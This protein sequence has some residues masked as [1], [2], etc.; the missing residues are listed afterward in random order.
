MAGPYP[1]KLIHPIYR[2]RR[3]FFFFHCLAV[4]TPTSN[5]TFL[6]SEFPTLYTLS[7]K[8][9]FQLHHDPVAALFK[10]WVF[11]EKLVERLFAEHQLPPLVENTQHRRLEELKRQ[12]LLPRQVEDMLHLLKR[13]GNVAAH[14][15]SGSFQDAAVLLESVFHLGK[16]LVDSY[17]V[18]HD[19]GV[20]PT[21]LVP[22]H[23]YTQQE[24]A[25]LETEK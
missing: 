23:R 22:T 15:N 24:L 16:W 1:G 7:T 21:F 10:L 12:G 25:K 17:S 13:K 3:R 19:P 6:R 2:S 14:E 20:P 4:S 9:E 5:F 11:G 8:A 18:M